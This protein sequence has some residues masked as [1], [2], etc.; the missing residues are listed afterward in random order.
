MFCS[1]CFVIWLSK[2]RHVSQFIAL[3]EFVGLTTVASYTIYVYNI[4]I[5]TIYILV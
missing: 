4:Y 5:I 1:V 3:R 2:K